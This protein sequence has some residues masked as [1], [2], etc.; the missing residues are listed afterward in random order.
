M[1]AGLAF[2]EVVINTKKQIVVGQP[3]V[4]AYYVE[5]IQEWAGGAFHQSF[6]YIGSNSALHDMDIPLKDGVTERP[7]RVLDWVSPLYWGTREQATEDIDKIRSFLGGAVSNSETE[8]IRRK[9]VNTLEF[10]NTRVS[11]WEGPKRFGSNI[12]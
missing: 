2:G 9:Y 4:D 12:S 5:S 8:V 3:I 7:D 1:R 6:P 11:Y 10:L